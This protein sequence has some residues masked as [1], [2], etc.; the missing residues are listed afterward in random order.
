MAQERQQGLTGLLDLLGKPQ[1]ASVCLFDIP[2]KGGATYY[3]LR[4]M[5]E[6]L[7]QGRGVLRLTCGADGALIGT[8]HYRD[9]G[10]SLTLTG[11][12]ELFAAHMPKFQTILVNNLVGWTLPEA[13]HKKSAPVGEGRP[14]W[15][16]AITGLISRLADAWKAHLEFVVHDFLPVCP[17][18][19]LLNDEEQSRYCGVPG[20]DGCKACYER[21]FMRASVGPSFSIAR[22]RASWNSF[23][24]RADAVICPS[25]SCRDILLRA[26]S[27]T[28]KALQVIPHAP[29]TPS[30][31]PLALPGRDT[32][33][34][35]AVVGHITVPKGA[36]I[37]RDIALLLQECHPRA[38]LTLV[39]TLA[40]PGV[41]LPDNV[42]VTGPYD[43]EG[44]ADVLHNLGVTVSLIPSLCPETFHY[45]TQE[46]MT[47]GLP[48]VCFDLGA[49][50]E[51]IRNWEHGMT[52]KEVSAQAALDAL[53]RLD[54]R[55]YDAPLP[56]DPGLRPASLV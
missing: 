49:P 19:I 8:V 52:V 50:A 45:V 30:M 5:E 43:K 15:I 22:W 35:I 2:R 21:P 13:Y 16:P 38:R 46:L 9:L 48:L 37:V 6:Y 1:T 31:T 44:L 53:E 20:P 24:N 40:A 28:G 4:R 12:P 54:A 25:S 55:R 23:L 39:G 3:S 17:N 7:E 56:P 14:R 32:V 26:F 42:L 36:R 11:L 41:Q 47:L 29:L 10:A 33:M 51:R 34:H 27:P 18:F